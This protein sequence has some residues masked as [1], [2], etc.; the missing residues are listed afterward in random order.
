M[1]F[2]PQSAAPRP[3][4]GDSNQSPYRDRWL[5]HHVD[6][7]TRR[8]LERDERVFLRQSLSTP[9]LDVLEEAAGLPS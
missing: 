6:A 5:E 4:E 3:S 2:G 7:A 9:C 1:T 8:L